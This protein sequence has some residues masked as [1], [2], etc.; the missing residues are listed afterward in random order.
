MDAISILAYVVVP[1]WITACLA[2]G[3][4]EEIIK[5][6]AAYVKIKRDQ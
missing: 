1:T 4:Y 5:D 6:G 2:W 3:I